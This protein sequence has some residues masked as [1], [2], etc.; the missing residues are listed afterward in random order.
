MLNV[1]IVNGMWFGGGLVSGVVA[2]LVALVVRNKVKTVC[3]TNRESLD[4][5]ITMERVVSRAAEYLRDHPEIDSVA[6]VNYDRDNVP[7]EVVAAVKKGIP[8][9][10]RHILLLAAIRNDES[11]KVFAVFF[12][13]KMELALQKSLEDNLF[14][15]NR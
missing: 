12:A 2:T 8:E 7:K 9:N 3:K 6:V 10:V 15:I 5:V 13:Q 1:M 11:Q 14:V 4:D